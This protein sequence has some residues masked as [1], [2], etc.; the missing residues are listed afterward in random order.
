[1]TERKSKPRARTPSPNPP[2]EYSMIQFDEVRDAVR[3]LGS[4]YRALKLLEIDKGSWYRLMVRQPQ[5]ATELRAVMEQSKDARIMW[6]VGKI[7]EH[8]DNDVVVAAMFALKREDPSY[9]ESYNVTTSSAPTDYII[10]L[11]SDDTP[12]LADVTPARILGE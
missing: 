4:V 8:V 7:D 1:V 11:S 3:V 5:L 9:R 12:Q 10:D 6:L 2:T